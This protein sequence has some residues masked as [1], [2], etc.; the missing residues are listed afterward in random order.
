[1][2]KVARVGEIQN[3]IVRES[4]KLH[5]LTDRIELS[6]IANIP[7]GTGLGSSGTFGVG[8]LKAICAKTHHPM[9]PLQLAQEATRIQADILKRPI[10]LQDQYIAAFGGIIC[11]TISKKGEVT[12]EPLQI[13]PQVLHQLEDNLVMFFTGYSRDADQ[14]LKEQDVKSKK[15]DADM[16]R[17]L[18]FV[19][20]L[21]YES[22]EALEAGDLKRFGQLMDVHWQH[23]KKRSGNMSNPIIDRWYSKAMKNGAIG[24]KLV[25]AGGG[26]F[27]MF[28]T[29]SPNELRKAMVQEG[30][31]EVRFKFDFEGAKLIVHE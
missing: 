8:V 20:K 2:E 12:V 3:D 5:N 16:M 11:F 14:I 24:G 23:K 15:T 4:L 9:M 17:N 21:G 22:K 25:G 13:K 26:G 6:S 10:G 27:L 19:K 31:V 30:L 29:E 7:S 18:D 1:M 28:Y